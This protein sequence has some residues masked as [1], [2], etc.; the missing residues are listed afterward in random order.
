ML[1]NK[2]KILL[3]SLHGMITEIYFRVAENAEF[4]NRTTQDYIA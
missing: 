1:Y 4:V 3:I 2:Q